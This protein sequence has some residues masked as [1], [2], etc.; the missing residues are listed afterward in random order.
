MDKRPQLVEWAKW[1]VANRA[2]FTYEMVRPMPSIGNRPGQL[3]WIGD[4]SG[5][6]TTLYKWSRL[7]DP[8]NMGY[9]GSG[10]TQTLYAHAAKITVSQALPGDVV[11]YDA[12]GPLEVQHTALI[13]EGGI[14]PLTVSMGQQGDPSYVRVSQDGR[15]PFYCR[16]VT[17]DG[18]PSVSTPAGRVPARFRP[19]GTPPQLE[20][21]IKGDEAW[22]VYLRLCLRAAGTWPRL[23]PVG[24]GGFGRLTHNAVIRYQRKAHLPADGIV[25]AVTWAALGVL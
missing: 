13:V 2:A 21:K 11:V 23:W 7:P 24:P 25:N 16:F 15:T 10:N 17:N 3:P 4:C 8:N 9:D 18:K 5:F 6:V 20:A 12:T 1:S 22:I 14:D 19:S